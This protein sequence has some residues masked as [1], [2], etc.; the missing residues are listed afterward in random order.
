MTNIIRLHVEV[1]LPRL[2]IETPIH[3]TIHKAWRILC[4]HATMCLCIR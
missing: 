3:A 2:N 4:A 1:Y